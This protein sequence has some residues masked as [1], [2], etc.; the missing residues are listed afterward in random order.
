MSSARRWEQE[1]GHRCRR[2]LRR[3]AQEAHTAGRAKGIAQGE[4]W[5]IAPLPS[6]LARP[7]AAGRPLA[8][9]FNSCRTLAR[10]R[11]MS[12]VVPLK[13]IKP[14]LAS[15]VDQPPEGKHW[16]HEIKLTAIALKSWLSV[17]R[18]AYSPATDMTGATA[19]PPSSA[20]HL[21][22]RASQPSLMVRPSSRMATALLTSRHFNPPFTIIPTASSCMPSI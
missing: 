14:Q 19:I 2:G 13:F 18:P 10:V 17:G 21:I 8:W 16:I 22:S 12:R 4:R 6:L 5:S 9:D 11:G 7:G 3:L 20:R 1:R 15:P